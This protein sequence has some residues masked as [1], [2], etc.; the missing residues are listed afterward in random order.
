[1][2]KTHW[3]TDEERIEA[4]RVFSQRFVAARAGVAADSELAEA[5]R[6]T[7]RERFCRRAALEV[8]I[9]TRHGFVE[10]PRDDPAAFLYQDVVAPLDVD[11]LNNGELSPTA[12]CIVML[13]LIKGDRIGARGRWGHGPHDDHLGEAAGRLGQEP[14]AVVDA[15]WIE[16]GLVRRAQENLAASPQVTLRCAIRSGGAAAR[17]LTC[18]T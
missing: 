12:T 1:M 17:V 2:R 3:R 16:P 10:A 14:E 9:L 13:L 5:F 4:H 6:T 7:P 8:E 18:P 11:G 15:Y